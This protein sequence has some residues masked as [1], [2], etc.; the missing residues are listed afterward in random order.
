[1][2]VPTVND[3]LDKTLV[4]VNELARLASQGSFIFRG[5]TRS[6]NPHISSSLYRRISRQYPRVPFDLMDLSIIQREML[7]TAKRFTS[8]TDEH[9]ILATLRH[10]GGPVNLVDFT[11]DYN[12]ALFFASDGSTADDN[13]DGRLIVLDR[14]RLETFVPAVPTNR[15]LVQKSIFVV[16]N[17]GRGVI[18]PSEVERILTVPAESKPVIRRHLRDSHD[19]RLE[20]IY[21][22]LLGFIGLQDRFT[23]LFAELT[24]SS[25]AADREDFN[26]AL[27]GLSALVDLP[28][29][30]ILARFERGKIYVQLGQYP[31]AVADLG[32]VIDVGSALP[33]G[34]LGVAHMERGQGLLHIGEISPAT[35]DFLRARELFSQE[36]E[37]LASIMDVPLAMAFLAQA[38]WDEARILLQKALDA[39]YR[40]GFSFR[41]EFGSVSEFNQKFNVNIPQDLAQ[42]LDIPEDCDKM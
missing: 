17:E 42:I 26:A 40:E 2:S 3:A 31:Q 19:I 24:A 16:P 12:V 30:D 14:N 4:L 33:A 39:G 1:M 7:G 18:S 25:A 41:E 5:E 34:H 8:E 9:E 13:E 10:N 28:L 27:D 32:V 22:D 37:P 36:P 15:V 21:N 11:T 23:S 20:T 29:Y 35:E 38:K 6:S